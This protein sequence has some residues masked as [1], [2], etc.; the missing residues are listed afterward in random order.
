MC[1]DCDIFRANGMKLR[2]STCGELASAFG[3]QVH[4]LPLNCSEPRAPLDADECLCWI[5]V[6]AVA[7]QHGMT[8]EDPDYSP[9]SDHWD[10]YALRERAGNLGGEGR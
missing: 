2:T 9:G 3:M 5:D 4:D 6:A 7:K 10:A 1:L 8:F